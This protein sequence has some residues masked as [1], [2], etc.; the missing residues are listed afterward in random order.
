ML[1][2]RGLIRV[3]R[4]AAITTAASSPAIRAGAPGFEPGIAGPKPAALPLGYAPPRLSI[5][6]RR[7]TQTLSDGGRDGKAATASM[8]LLQAAAQH[9]APAHRDYRSSLAGQRKHCRTA[10]E[11]AKPPRPR[12]RCCKQQLSTWLRPTAT[13]DPVSQGNANTV[14]R[15]PRRQS[16]HGLDV[17][18]ASSSSALGYAP[19]HQEVR[20]EA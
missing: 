4:P 8:S 13:I 5:Q 14:G 11:T 6:S 16:R 1:R 2:C 17:A 18:A 15:R 20:R 3:P 10:A 7:A 9:L 19:L 12:C